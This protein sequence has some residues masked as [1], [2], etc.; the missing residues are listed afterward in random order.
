MAEPRVIPMLTLRGEGL[1][2]T[3]AF[4][5]PVYVGDPINAVKLFNDKEVDELIVTD[6][7]RAPRGSELQ[8]AL[9]EDLATEAFMPMAYAGRLDSI[10]QAERLFRLG[11]EKVVMNTATVTNFDLIG[12]IS[13]RFGAQSCVV[14]IDVGKPLFGKRQVMIDCGRRRTGLDPI[15]HVLRCQEAGAGEMLLRSIP[16]DGTMAGYDL[17]LIAAAAAVVNVPLVAVGGAGTLDHL[18]AALRAGAHSVAAGSM[19]VFQGKHRGVL[20]N[21]PQREQ[22]DTLLQMEVE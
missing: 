10:D 11:Y 6:I 15:E 4:K 14:S 7:S 17:E 22:I 8:Y 12:Q 16:S 9:L 3:V 21:Y 2:R 5:K 13:N 19:F 20:I 1:Y 18:A